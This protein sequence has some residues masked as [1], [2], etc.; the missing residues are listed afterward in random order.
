M[1]LLLFGGFLFLL[2]DFIIDYEREE[3]K[4][5]E[6]KKNKKTFWNSIDII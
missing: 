5:K 4:Q 2:I 6:N 3:R 1:D